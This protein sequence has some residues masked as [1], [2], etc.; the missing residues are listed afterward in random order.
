ME[1]RECDVTQEKRGTSGNEFER[2][3]RL[4]FMQVMEIRVCSEY[5]RMRKTGG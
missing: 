5:R 1:R 3:T 2:Y 4:I